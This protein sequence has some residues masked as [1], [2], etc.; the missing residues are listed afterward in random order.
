MTGYSL[1]LLIWL[2]G[3]GLA[4]GPVRGESLL[5]WWVLRLPGRLPRFGGLAVAPRALAA[6][7]EYVI[8]GTGGGRFS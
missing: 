1:A 4:V 8:P 6:P 3:Y 2:P 7:L 5:R